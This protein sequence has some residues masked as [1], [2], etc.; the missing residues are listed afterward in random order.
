MDDGS[1]EDEQEGQPPEPPL[2]G[3]AGGRDRKGW[4][5]LGM[6]VAGLLAFGGLLLIGVL[7]LY[8]VLI[9]QWASNK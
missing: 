8:L 2:P 6:V 9:N 7:V 3:E 5:T 4:T 1:L